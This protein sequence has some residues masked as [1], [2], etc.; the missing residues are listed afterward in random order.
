MNRLSRMLSFALAAPILAAI[1]GCDEPLE[2]AQ[3]I[4]NVRVLGARVEVAGDPERTAPAPGETINVRWLVAA[5]SPAPVIGWSFFACLSGEV[6]AGVGHCDAEPFAL[7]ASPAPSSDAPNFDLELP[8]DVDLA[9]MASLNLFG[10]VCPDTQPTGD[11]L[12]PVC[13][14]GERGTRVASSLE[15]SRDDQDN[16]NPNFAPDAVTF[17]GASWSAPDT[18]VD[19]CQPGAGLRVSAGNHRVELFAGD[20]AREPL[21]KAIESDPDR[22]S[23]LFSHF[24]SAGELN[25]PFS[26][27]LPETERAEV[28]VDWIAAE[29]AAAAG[30]PVYFWFVLRD[31]RGGA[32]FQ[33]RQLCV[34]P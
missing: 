9:Q 28:S 24:S 12:T 18:A 11:P 1:S 34:V 7:R 6:N 3:L 22:E 17:D 26:S 21:P 19:P 32:S 10:L 31:L 30:D 25:R 13:E 8:S 4:Q 27:V 2:R 29:P 14:G 20:L 33:A 15:L 16:H 23:L 5:P